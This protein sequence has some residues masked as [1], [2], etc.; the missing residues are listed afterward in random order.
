MTY[1]LQQVTAFKT[2]DGKVFRSEEE[3]ET[4]MK[5]L[6]FLEKKRAI[7]EKLKYCV[8]MGYDYNYNLLVER[9]FLKKHKQLVLDML[10][11]C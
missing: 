4:H 2:P 6:L 5:N 10:A 8:E 3:A 7:Q 1:I 11:Y 9:E